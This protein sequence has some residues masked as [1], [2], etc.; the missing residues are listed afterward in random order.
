MKQNIFEKNVPSLDY[1]FIRWPKSKSLIKNYLL[2]DKKEPNFEKICNSFLKDMQCKNFAIFKT[3]LKILSKICSMNPTSN[4]YHDQHHFKSVLLI[5]CILAKKKKLNNY[6]KIL[7]IIISLTHDMNH[8]GKRIIKKNYYQEEKT[9]KQLKYILFKKLLNYKRWQRI[10]KIVLNTFFLIK[11]EKSNDPIEQIVL[12]ADVAAAILFGWDNGL[13]LAS[14]LKHE[15]N[16][17]VSSLKLYK[18]FVGKLKDRK[19]KI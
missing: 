11:P 3:V 16:L 10:R 9:L 2:N 13:K 18:N 4:K 5:S 19:L 8:Q 14:K 1:L 12:N 6:D 15:S 17:D 7:V